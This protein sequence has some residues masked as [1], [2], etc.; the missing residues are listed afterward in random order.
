MG[1]RTWD[2]RGDNGRAARLRPQEATPTY[3]LLLLCAGSL[4]WSAARHAGLRIVAFQTSI[5]RWPCHDAW[6]A[7]PALALLRLVRGLAS[8]RAG[9][10][11]SI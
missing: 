5:S 6:N 8:L 9:L 7:L 3:C 2:G 11:N 10:N 4:H 1:L